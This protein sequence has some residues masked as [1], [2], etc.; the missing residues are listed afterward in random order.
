M[1][2]Q[3]LAG[4][5]TGKPT[6][7]YPVSTDFQTFTWLPYRVARACVAADKEPC[8]TRGNVY[9]HSA[10]A[11]S[12]NRLG[13]LWHH[14]RVVRNKGGYFQA[15]K[16]IAP[17]STYT[18][19]GLLQNEAVT[20]GYLRLSRSCWTGQF[21]KEK[22]V[23]PLLG[24]LTVMHVKKHPLLQVRSLAHDANAPMLF[25]G[26]MGCG[27]V[28]YLQFPQGR[29]P[30]SSPKATFGVTCNKESA[31]TLAGVHFAPKQSMGSWYRVHLYSEALHT[32]S[33]GH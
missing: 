21:I 29:F 20:E 13:I 10:A 7:G 16:C 31:G 24:C 6:H 17:V 2:D 12:D 23:G 5:T 15:A 1:A 4:F 18:C 22:H 3:Y 9:K 28:P 25:P 19:T 30:P 8:Q 33:R 11:P 26:N 27:T 14:D 32:R